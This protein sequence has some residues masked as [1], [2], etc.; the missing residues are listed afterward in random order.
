MNQ[1]PLGLV[2]RI[3]TRGAVWIDPS[4]AGRCK[5][6]IAP[7]LRSDC[8][9]DPSLENIIRWLNTNRERCDGVA[10]RAL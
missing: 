7:L 6:S 5:S 4:E 2:V 10:K 8:D 9:Q 1:N 3:P